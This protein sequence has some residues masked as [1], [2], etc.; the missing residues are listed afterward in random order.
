MVPKDCFCLPDPRLKRRPSANFFCEVIS[1]HQQEG[2]ASGIELLEV[3][4][5][6]NP[7]EARF[8]MAAVSS[9]NLLEN[10]SDG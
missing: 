2:G 8:S 5:I 3:R 4:V 9:L 6:G 1:R 7:A 10:P